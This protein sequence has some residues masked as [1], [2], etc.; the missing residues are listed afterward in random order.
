MCSSDLNPVAFDFCV[1]KIMGFDYKKLP[2]LEKALKDQSMI[3]EEA[4][5]INLC[6]N[7]NDFNRL[8][9]DIEIDFKFEP[10]VGW[11]DYL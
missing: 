7:A 1:A 8:V 2:T 9:N 4:S 3:K 6:S 5:E 11:R 10:S